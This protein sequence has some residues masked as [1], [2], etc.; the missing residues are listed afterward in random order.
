MHFP[1]LVLLPS[2]R[3]RPSK[4]DVERFVEEVLFPYQYL[5][6]DRLGVDAPEVVQSGWWDWYR[7][8]GSFES[9]GVHAARRGW[10]RFFR[11]S[12]Y[13]VPRVSDL[14]ARWSADVVPV[15]IVTPDGSVLGG[16]AWSDEAYSRWEDEAKRLL[17]GYRSHFYVVVDCHK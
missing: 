17:E 8:G 15:R 11:A 16:N 1:V 14:L 4:R 9:D 12:S 6:R 3:D 5:E 13:G 2:S 7:I 10:V